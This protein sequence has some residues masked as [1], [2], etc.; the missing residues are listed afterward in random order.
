MGVLNIG[1]SWVNTGDGRKFWEEIA[2]AL[3]GREQE[4]YKLG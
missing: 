4:Y 1:G 3:A 2:N